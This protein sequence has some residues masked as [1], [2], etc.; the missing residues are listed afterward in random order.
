M[1]VMIKETDVLRFEIFFLCMAYNN[2]NIELEFIGNK[3]IKTK[4]ELIV[5][6]F[7]FMRECLTRFMCYHWFNYKSIFYL[8]F[9]S[10]S[11][12]Y[13]PWNNLIRSNW[14]LFNVSNTTNLKYWQQRLFCEMLAFLYY[15]FLFSSFNAS[16]IH[17]SVQ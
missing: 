16:S 8:C 1:V 13:S 5:W 2:K 3:K 15:I 11:I 14:P 10:N 9:V 17:A 4:N 7:F 12:V 6:A